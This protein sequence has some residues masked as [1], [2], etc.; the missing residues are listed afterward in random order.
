MDQ[1]LQNVVIAF[2][3]TSVEVPSVDNHRVILSGQVGGTE[4]YAVTKCH[5]LFTK[6][7]MMK[8]TS[9]RSSCIARIKTMNKIQRTKTHWSHVALLFISIRHTQDN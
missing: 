4:E 5:A 6:N 3:G 9:T 8:A 7:T 1:Q 2:Q